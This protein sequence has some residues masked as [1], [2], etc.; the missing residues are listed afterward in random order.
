MGRFLDGG[1]EEALKDLDLTQ[2]GLEP[3]SG[4]ALSGVRSLPG[5]GHIPSYFLPTK[6]FD[7]CF[8]HGCL[9]APRVVR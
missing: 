6:R 4:V 2:V 7:T 8:G 9:G 1:Q 5:D 3:S